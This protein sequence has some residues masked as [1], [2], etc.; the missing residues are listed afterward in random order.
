MKKIILTLFIVF[1]FIILFN[2]TNAQTIQ[3]YKNFQPFKMAFIPDTHISFERNNDWILNNE[4]FVIFQDTVKS[5]S[6]VPNLNFIVFGGDLTENKDKQL[7][8]LPMFLDAIYELKIPYY[9]IFGDR[10]ADLDGEYTKAH[11]AAEFR[12][13]GFNDPDKT[14]WVQEPV[15]N[16]MLIGLDTT[17]QNRFSGE[18][19][20]EQ[21]LWLD[22]TLKNNKDKFTVITMHHS[23]IATNPKDFQHPWKNFVLTN[24]QDFLSVIQKYPQVKVVL[25]GHHHLNSTQK[26]NNTLFISSPSI[27][28]YP[29]QFKLLTVYPDR[30]EVENKKISFKQIIKKAKQTLPD[31]EYAKQFDPLK[32]KNITKLQEGDKFS[33]EKVYY[34]Y[35]VTK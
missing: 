11:F 18:I 34:F 8:D 30:V 15:E 31:T 16:V 20:Q 19:S 3:E 7:N 1:S 25:S 6:K 24:S 21:L 17:L 4:S 33:Q 5:L 26:M 2:K 28:T 12:R 29:N 32:P 14:Y 9:V 22:E 23:P 35:Q 13:N 27:V 10:D